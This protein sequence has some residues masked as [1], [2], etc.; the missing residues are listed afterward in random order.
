MF[1][2]FIVIAIIVAVN[3]KNEAVAIVPAFR[4]A[5]DYGQIQLKSQD[6]INCYWL[7]N[8]GGPASLTFPSPASVVAFVPARRRFAGQEFIMSITNNAGVSL[9]LI[10]GHANN[11]FVGFSSPVASPGF[12]VV[13]VKLTNVT[14]GQ[15]AVSYIYVAD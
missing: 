7:Q 4:A 9:S 3:S 1:W 10:P 15:Q 11:T 5:S 8:H 6:V 14:A 2:V 12:L 13:R